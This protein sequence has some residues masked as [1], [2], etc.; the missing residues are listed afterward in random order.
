MNDILCDRCG[1]E[2]ALYGSLLC[3]DCA[4]D[5]SP[6]TDAENAPT[7]NVAREEY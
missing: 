4:D 5:R 7:A 1:A 6:T 2:P 3:A